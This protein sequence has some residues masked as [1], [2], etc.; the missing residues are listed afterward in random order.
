MQVFNFLNA[1]KLKKTEL[2]V[3]SNIFNNYLFIAIVIGIFML[4]LFI[5]Q[6]GGKTFELV[7][8]SY[9]QHFVCIVIGATGVVWN[10]IVK[11]LIPDGFMNNFSLLR[12]ERGEE[13]IN[14]DSI[15]ERWKE[16][17]ATE[18]RKSKMR[19]SRSRKGSQDVR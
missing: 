19:N 11:M 10:I 1:R 13:V 14:P 12:E 17:P 2:N 6:C 3:F 9:H 8:L 18:R 4:Q 15:F 16:H 7:P 5:V